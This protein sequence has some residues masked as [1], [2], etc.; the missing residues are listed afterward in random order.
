MWLVVNENN[1]IKNPQLFRPHKSQHSTIE[2]DANLHRDTLAKSLYSTCSRWAFL[3]IRRCQLPQSF[4]AVQDVWF[5]FLLLCLLQQHGCKWATRGSMLV[6]PLPG[7]KKWCSNS[8]VWGKHSRLV[9][10]RRCC[11]V[12]SDLVQSPREPLHKRGCTKPH[13]RAPG[14]FS[15]FLRLVLA[16]A[17]SAEICNLIFLV[18]ADVYCTLLFNW[19]SKIRPWGSGLVKGT[20]SLKRTGVLIKKFSLMAFFF[21]LFHQMLKEVQC[22]RPLSSRRGRR[23]WSPVDWGGDGGPVL[24]LTVKVPHPPTSPPSR[25]TFYWPTNDPKWTQLCV[26]K[27]IGSLLWLWRLVQPGTAEETHTNHHVRSEA[28]N[29]QACA[30]I[31]W[32]SCQQPPTGWGGVKETFAQGPLSSVFLSP[33]LSIHFSPCCTLFAPVA[34][35]LCGAAASIRGSRLLLLWLPVL[36]NDVPAHFWNK[37][38]LLRLAWH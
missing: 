27:W 22:F 10:S 21:S 2:L 23:T 26:W 24:L 35:Q 17:S 31:C 18:H 14:F 13:L 29:N 36:A 30:V 4:S 5:S 16:R 12:L 25:Q 20:F 1:E 9:Q 7:H 6:E 38:A 3:S 37:C 19:Q 8:E 28:R 32:A 11:T 34:S 15:S 33:R